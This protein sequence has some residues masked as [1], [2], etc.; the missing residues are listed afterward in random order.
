MT[1][2]LETAILATVLVASPQTVPV[3]SA[4]Q[5]AQAE[6]P[7]RIIPTDSLFDRYSV[8]SKWG[9]LPS[10]QPW[11]GVTTGV[12]ADGKGTVVVLVRTAPYFR[13]FTTDGRF[14]KAWGDAGLFGQ[15]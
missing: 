10:G 11:G 5:A 6:A 14:V 4:Q 2:F 1:R 9:Q 12:A 7:L 15:P 13:V 8:E 3:I